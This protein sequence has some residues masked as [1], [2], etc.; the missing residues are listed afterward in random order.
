MRWLILIIVPMAVGFGI[1]LSSADPSGWKFDLLPRSSTAN[2]TVKNSHAEPQ[3]RS[4]IYASGIVEGS[5]RDVPLRFE[6]SGRV[7]SI[8]VATGDLVKKGQL[9]AKL[10]PATQEQKLKL[11]EAKLALS[12]SERIRL[13]NGER[14]ETIQVAKDEVVK[15]NMRVRQANQR[16]ERAKELDKRNAGTAEETADRQWEYYV[17]K[18]DEILAQSRVKEIEAPARE[19]DLAI[20]NAKIASAEAEVAFARTEL[21]KTQLLAPSDGLILRTAGEPGQLMGPQDKEPLFVMVDNSQ[22]RVRAY[23]EELDALTVKPGQSAYVI[24]DGD[25]ETR[26]HGKVVSCAPFMVPKKYMSNMPGERVDVKVLEVMILLEE[27]GALLVGLPV[28]VFIETKLDEQ[29]DGNESDPK[30]PDVASADEQE[31]N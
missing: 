17:V 7:T 29:T 20:A 2:A 15:S 22:S 9:L 1:A 19:D 21:E 8:G 28:D 23:V 14:E 25:P 18:A 12:K 24:A 13:A 10:D 30:E 27:K 11:A 31:M 5:Q 26:H 3:R 16:W 4:I 6:I